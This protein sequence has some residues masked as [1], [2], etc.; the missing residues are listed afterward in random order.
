MTAAKPV[1]GYG[2]QIR[3]AAQYA[4]DC[5]A[6]YKN[7]LRARNRVITE[8]IDHGYSGHQAARDADV[9]QPHIIRILSL[10]ELDWDGE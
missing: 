10:S 9:K 6:L 3:S 5:K 2:D 7:A 4:R 8:A 1:Q